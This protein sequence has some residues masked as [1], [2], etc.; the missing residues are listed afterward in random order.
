MSHRA[1]PNWFDPGP[2]ETG[3]TAAAYIFFDQIILGLLVRAVSGS[4]VRA[5][6]TS[7]SGNKI[8][9]DHKAALSQDV[10]VGLSDAKK[11]MNCQARKAYRACIPWHLWYLSSRADAAMQILIP[12]QMVRCE[13][14]KRLSGQEERKHDCLHTHMRVASRKCW[15][16]ERT[17]PLHGHRERQADMLAHKL[18]RGVCMHVGWTPLSL[19]KKSKFSKGSLW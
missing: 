7:V 2:S 4:G 3:A 8:S 14:C 16:H 9:V 5:F 6:R 10:Q 1:D 15:R 18:A 11:Q 17:F 13:P 12:H 19:R